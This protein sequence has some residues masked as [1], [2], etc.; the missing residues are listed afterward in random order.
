MRYAS[1]EPPIVPAI[2][3]TGGSVTV[4]VF[5]QDA[6]ALLTL[7]TSAAVET[8]VPGL[9]QFSLSNV[10]N[11]PAGYAQLVVIFSHS[12]GAKDFAKIVVRGV[13][14]DTKKIIQLIM[15]GI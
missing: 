7:S 11:P 14:D 13:L 4:Q 9:W 10:T 5:H 6:N 2:L 8:A 12:S 1:T 15:T 3:P